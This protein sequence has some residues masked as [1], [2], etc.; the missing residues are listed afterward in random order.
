MVG[1]DAELTLLLESYA[2][3]EAGEAQVALVTGEA[4][5][6]KTRLV[7]EFVARLPEG[8]VVAFGHAVPLS[9]DAIPY[10]AAADVLRSLVREIG[11]ESVRSS[12]GER[13]RALA[14]L[15]P[16]LG[17][18]AD[19]SVDR[20]GLFGAVQD[21]LADLSRDRT[22]VVV[23]EDAHWADE[24]S[25]DLLSFLART[26]V[27]GRLLLVLTTRDV[28]MAN[29]VVDSVLELHRLP[30]SHAIGL[31]PLARQQIE[32]Q[33]RAI[34]VR[35][36]EDTLAEIARLSEGIPLYVEE[37]LSQDALPPSTPL[38]LDLAVRLT[39]L[40]KAS[41][42]VVRLAALEA[43]P[44]RSDLLRVVA[45][46]DADEVEGL[47][48]EA[49]SAGLVEP[50]GSEWRFHHELLRLSTVASLPRATR[51][52]GHR[53]WASALGA[54]EDGRADD[55]VAA[56]D[57]VDEAAS[58]SQEALEARVVA[59]R[60]CEA[61]AQGVV[62]AVQWQSVL[63]RVWDGDGELSETEHEEAL[64]GA[65]AGTE[66]WP[67]ALQLA[68]AEAAATSGRGEMREVWLALTQLNAAWSL[69]QPPSVDPSL[70]DLARIMHRVAVSPARPFTL[71]LL[72]M[73][74]H[75]FRYLE[76]LDR[77]DEA[78]DLAMQVAS[79]LSVLPPGAIGWTFEERLANLDQRSGNLE[80]LW[81]I[82]QEGLAAVPVGDFQSRALLH[83]RAAA[84]HHQRRELLEGVREAERA[85]ELARA[86]ELSGF[87]WY[88]AVG[89]GQEL[90]WYAGR[91]D[92]V[93]LQTP[94]LLMPGFAESTNSALFVT[95]LVTALRGGTADP[96]PVV[97]S[98]EA[99]GLSAHDGSTG[100]AT[101]HLATVMHAIARE[102]ADPWEARETL[103]PCLEDDALHIHHH[104]PDILALA[105]R[106]DDG[107]PE[108]SDYRQM[109]KRAAD[110][111]LDDSPF[112]SAF[113]EL[114][115]AELDGDH[116]PSAVT[117]WSGLVSTFEAFPAPWYAAWCGLRLGDALVRADD[118]DGA[119]EALGAAL[120]SAEGLGA[121]PLADQ[122]RGLAARARLKLPGHE[123]EPGETGPLTARE[124]EVL[125]LLV[126]GMTND[127]IGTTLF[128]SP[129]T[130]S[131]HVSHILAKLQAS[132][133]TEVAAVA[134]RRGLVTGD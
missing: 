124:H 126:Q 78:V 15:V 110:R 52:A 2:R 109:V 4:G 64:L 23:V 116:E 94:Q 18:G 83:A 59:A 29:G 62:S 30:N 50:T 80:A 107:R 120:T 75:T 17:Q 133:R 57:H 21:V 89:T 49:R 113:A 95:F 104:V 22:V 76:D 66:G 12:M 69:A 72:R 32:E 127:Q 132:N 16:Q 134:H 28:G 61:V 121:Q 14:P 24:S 41:A 19:G 48:E 103:S 27:R 26:S 40:G 68:D 122:I 85:A 90:N 79:R 111:A 45:D 77:A 31:R 25:V 55:L 35:V 39:T 117:T 131:V 88:I 67:R 115:A 106:L 101:R 123:P 114:V 119:A 60:A 6:G 99:P 42:E 20:F 11:P 5:I 82:V 87:V 9:G 56:A 105:A 74:A 125:Q 92:E 97:A 36:D 70:E 93:L 37:L 1:R 71:R 10:G 65:I 128:M 51:A 3:A 98:F 102:R 84:V 53:R 46:R 100:F 81:A 38:R 73:L 118:R 47:L 63:R 112:D 86:P 43:R 129:R 44:F 34:A 13:A 108:L 33:A 54:L 130:A 91:W 7:R 96:G 58:P 8:T